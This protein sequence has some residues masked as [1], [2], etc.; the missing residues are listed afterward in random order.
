MQSKVGDGRAWPVA[1]CFGRPTAPSFTLLTLLLPPILSAI[2][3]F[4][5]EASWGAVPSHACSGPTSAASGGQQWEPG[6]EGGAPHC[7]GRDFL[8]AG[9]PD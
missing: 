4:G 6:G 1:R 7:R 3:A 8:V 5:D 9:I 2:R